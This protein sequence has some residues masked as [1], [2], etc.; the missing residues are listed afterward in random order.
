MRRAII[1]LVVLIAIGSAGPAWAQFARADLSGTVTDPD[2]SPL[3]GVTVTARHE[4]TGATRTAVTAANGRYVFNG[5]AAATYTVVFELQGFR[6]VEHTGVRLLV[7]QD[8]ALNVQMEL[9]GVEETVT[10]T[11]E[12]PL[13]DTTSKEVGGN[14][15]AEDFTT[16]PTQGRSFV[17][18]AALLPGVQQSPDTQSTASDSLF[19]NGQDDNNNSF[20]VDG[21]GNDDDVIGARAGAQVRTAIEAIQEFQIMTSQFD[22][23]FGRSVG[24]VLNAITKSGSNVVHGSGFFYYQDSDLNKANFFTRRSG[25]E[26]P[27]FTF[28]SYGGTLGGPIVKDR[29]H[30]FGSYERQT[31]NEG[32]ARQFEGR[33]DLDFTTTERNVLQNWMAKLDWQA[34]QDHK[35]GARFLRE[36]SPQF[37]QI[38]GGATTLEAAREEFDVDTSFVGSIDSVFSDTTVNNFRGSL[39]RENVAF[40]NP[41]FNNNGK[42]FQAQRALDVSESRPGILE[43]ANTVAQGR[44]N[45]S[46]QFDDTL[47]IFAPDWLGGDHDIRVGGNY[48]HKKE[49]FF[50]AGTA[51]GQFV[52]DTIQPFDPNDI[53]TYPVSFTI[54]VGSALGDDIV[55]PAEDYVAVFFQDDF[56]PTDNLTL[57]LG[58]RYDN[59]DIVPEDDNNIAPRLGIAW[60]PAGDGKTVIRGGWGRFYDRFQLGF[61]SGF[62]LDAAT[63]PSGFLVRV[64]ES[65]SNQN[66]FWETAQA[67]GITTLNGLRDALA[68]QLEANLGSA[69]NPTPTV[70]NPLRREPHADTLT[71]GAE[72]EIVPGLSVGVDWIHTENEDILVAADLN[73]FSLSQGGRPNISIINGQTTAFSNIT[74]Y[75]NAG[76]STYNGINVSLAR[77]FQD[78][79][80]GRFSGR[81]SYTY[82]HQ[83]GNAQPAAVDG[84][85]FQTRTETGYNFDTGEIIGA[86]L[87]LGLDNPASR[88][89]PASWNR[90]HN[91]VASWNYLV[92]GTSWKQSEG[93]YFSGVFRYMS[94]DRFTPLLFSRLDN[95][96]RAPAPAGT[97]GPNRTSDIALDPITA[98]GKLNSTR[99]PDFSRLDVSFRYRIPMGKLAGN[100]GGGPDFDLT[101]LL[102]IFNVTD[103]TNFSNTGSSFVQSSAFLIPTAARSPREIQL[104]VRMDW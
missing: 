95:N 55:I 49:T 90:S 84:L 47:S 8:A 18:F 62:F 42:T 37:N 19:I 99:R 17:L 58:V 13:V 16:L 25:L 34:H 46:K 50:N 77:R 2:G 94:G 36:W 7:G 72:R 52:F 14:L 48:A 98:S 86:P 82:G 5:L 83:S 24:G 56:Q 73:P 96:N 68:A 74:T 66:L 89:F 67:N 59:Q 63:L 40:A 28:K 33:P 29:L 79:P 41:G 103:R 12:A 102:D 1:L 70:D 30:F 92:P 45:D 43:G 51:N 35:I 101:V 88:G 93:L 9:G 44:V 54:R 75:L 61:W 64:P 38:I 104:G 3:P 71:I 31:P 26:K 4:G 11:A 69:F 22:A 65:G 57:N 32:I 60:D 53:T 39:T 20:N 80:V 15:T 76:S 100:R 97:Y 23:E 78:S 27:D 6:R 91:F 87:N 81:I 21:A 10:V 85:R